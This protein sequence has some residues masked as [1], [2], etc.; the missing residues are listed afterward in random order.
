MKKIILSLFL[1]LFLFSNANSACDDAPGDGVDYEGCAFSDEQNLTGTYLPNS[2]LSFTGFIKVIFD[3][4]IMMNSK[5]SNGNFPESSFIRANLYEAILDGGNFEWGAAGADRQ[6]ALNTPDPCYG[7]V[8]WDEQVTKNMGLPFAYL[9]KLRTTI[10]RDLGGAMSPFNAWMFI[11]GLETLPLRMREHAKNAQAVAEF[12][13]GNKKVESVTY[14]GLFEGAEKEK[15]DKYMTGGYGALIGFELPGGKEAGSKFID[16]LELLYH[17]ANI[18]DS[19]S[20]AI[21][22]ATT[23]HS[24]LSPE[25]QESA[26]VTPG[27]VRLSIGIE[28]V[29]DII[30]DISQALDK[31]S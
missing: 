28:N 24:Q 22:P 27:Y 30:A 10:L 3:K 26:G 7:G 20:L 25:E 14:P 2:N 11:Q 19:R 17:V 9:L 29:E 18:G 21:H 6:P 8:V 15:A 23:T 16:S 13:A 5:L 4:S 1:S 31:A 12:L